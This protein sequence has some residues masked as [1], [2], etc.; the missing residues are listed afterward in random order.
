M[1]SKMKFKRWFGHF[2]WIGEE[3]IPKKMLCT[4]M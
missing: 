2:M 1:E 3:K 4:K